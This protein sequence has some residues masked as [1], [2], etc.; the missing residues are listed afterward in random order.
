MKSAIR[1]SR[2]LEIVPL[3]ESQIYSLEKAGEFPKRFEISARAVAWNGDGVE[4]WLDARQQNP[5]TPD[6][7]MAKKFEK[8]PN[9][10][11][12]RS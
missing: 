9:H 1:K 11:K 12:A 2:L 4:A 3:S 5:A 8:N 7:S 6:P 10:S